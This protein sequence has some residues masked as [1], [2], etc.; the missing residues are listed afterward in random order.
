MHL[1]AVA[2][3][4]GLKDET[5]RKF[6]M[7]HFEKWDGAYDFYVGLF[8]EKKLGGARFVARRE[9]VEHL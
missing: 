8:A 1:R 5:V 3:A 2:T 4:Q 6:G 9:S 7:A